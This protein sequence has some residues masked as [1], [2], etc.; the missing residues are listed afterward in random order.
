MTEIRIFRA[1]DQDQVIALWEACDLVVA[2]NL[3]SLDISRK[4]DFQPDL[5]F[6]A[7]ENARIVGTVM[8][9]YEGHRGWVNYLAVS[10]DCRGQGLGRQLMQFAEE[11]LLAIGCPKINLQVRGTNA[12]VIAF[13]E[14]LGFRRDDTVGLGKRLDGR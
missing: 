9:G 10:P 8:A 11:Q 12:E 13:Y 6:V 7:E 3:P 2:W 5:F 4:V 1:S 14:R